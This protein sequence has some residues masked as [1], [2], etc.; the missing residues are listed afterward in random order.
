MEKENFLREK[1][2]KMVKCFEMVLVWKTDLKLQMSQK[3]N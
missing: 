1:S 2:M 3:D